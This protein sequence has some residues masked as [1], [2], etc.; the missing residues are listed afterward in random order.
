MNFG[1]RAG[2]FVLGGLAVSVGIM[3]GL[4]QQ[5]AAEL[6]RERAMIQEENSAAAGQRTVAPVRDAA[7]KDAAAELSALRAD[8]AALARLRTEIEQ[9]KTRFEA[10]QPAPA[11][12][13]TTAGATSYRLELMPAS[14]WKN[15]GRA[16]PRA[17]VETALWAAVGGDI[18]VLAD[19]ITLDAG[20][21][22]K[23]EALLAG[24]PPA[25]REHYASPEKLVALLTSKDVPVGAS[26][27]LVARAGTAV[28]EA[29]LTLVLQGETAT[30]SIELTLR[31]RDGN[32]R[33]VV[34]EDA[35]EKYGAMLR[36]E[37]AIAGPVR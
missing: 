15:L 36:G 17:A 19:T 10:I 13:P 33:L 1:T 9:L 34:P 7:S 18:E 31:Q 29:K 24:L 3:L 30:R 5:A 12:E 11:T 23:A 16:A 2:W 20:A 22:A 21:R 26:M 8:R 14:G 25:A 6:R 28:D 27:R 37:P 4:Q 35:I 32:W